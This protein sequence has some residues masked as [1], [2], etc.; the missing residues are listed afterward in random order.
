MFGLSERCALITGASG[1]IGAA[2]ARQLHAAGAVVCLS[3]T[4]RPALEA[5]AESLGERAHVVV[6]DLSVAAD[7][8]ALAKS[9][10]AAMGQID[11]LINNAGL[12][13]DGLALRM[14][15][16]DFA[17]VLEV[18][19]VSAFRL[20]R[21]ALRGM[22]RRRWGRIVSISSVVAFVGNPG[23]ANYAAS[24][25]GLAGMSRSLAAEVAAR[26]V[27]V[28]CIAPG[29]IASAM[30]QALT[31]EQRARILATIPAGALGEPADVAAAAAYLSSDAARYVTGQTIHVNGGMAMP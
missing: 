28:N 26:G 10:E 16:D 27:T 30:T 9:A 19:L 4:R 13:R 25:A 8:E 2:I 3:G 15:D 14:K 21:A 29:F 31:E 12:T 18:N 11:I 6:G 5:L 20:S 17:R 24:K 1:D 7:V 22:M 23:Q